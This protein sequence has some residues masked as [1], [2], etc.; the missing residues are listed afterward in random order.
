MR[1]P[2]LNTILACIPLLSSAAT[3]Q[4]WE[5]MEYGSLISSSVTLPWAANGEDLGGIVLKGVTVKLAP[6]A[7]ACFDTGELRWAGV[8]TN[9]REGLKLMGT[10][11]DGTHRPPERSRP[12]AIG[13]FLLGTSHGPGVA[14]NG[15]FRDLRSEPYVPVPKNQAH[16]QGLDRVGDAVVLHYTVGTTPVHELP[17]WVQSDTT[18]AFSRTVRVDAHRQPVSLLV[19]ELR[20][21]LRDHR[22]TVGLLPLADG[23]VQSFGRLTAAVDPLPIGARWEVLNGSRLILHLPPSTRP[24]TARLL[25]AP[26]A[27]TTAVEWIRRDEVGPRPA[28]LKTLSL[29]TASQ[30]TPG[31]RPKRWPQTVEVTAKL[32]TEDGAYA[33]DAVP[34][35]DENPWASWMRPGG[36]DFFPD[37]DRCAL[38]TW[39]G[40][41]WIGSGFRGPLGRVRW[42]RFAAGL[43][44]P[45]GLKIVR[46]QIHVLGRDQITRLLDIDGDGEADRYECF[47]NDVSIT[48]N[49]HEFSLDLHTDQ[50]GNFYFTKGGPLLGTDYWDPI[51]AHNGCV[52]KVSA[53]GKRLE[54]YATGLRAPNGSA[55]GQDGQVTC[56]D[57]EGIWTPVCR[58][59]WVKPGGFYGAM[60]L[61]HRE[62]RPWVSDPPLCWLPF[63]I[64]NSSGGQVWTD[65]RFGPLAHSL[66][67]LSYGKCRA[68]TV[69]R[70]TVG[71]VV[72][73][74]VVPLP[75][76][77][78]SS[79]MRAR[80]HPADGTL[81]VAGFKGWQTTAVR[82]G[83]LHRVRPTGRTFPRLSGVHA[84]PNH[85][86][87]EF[88]APLDRSSTLTADAFDVQ[89]WDY[90]WSDAY[91]S[92]LYSVAAP[93]KVT[94]KKGELRGDVLTIRSVVLAHDGR[95]VDLTLDGLKPAMQVMIR[96]S[97]RTS[98]GESIPL[99]YY[100]SIHR[101]K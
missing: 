5:A 67:H 4:R 11:Y 62:V 39:S 59:N 24:V 20:L 10:P 65:H 76:R 16:Y 82:D 91:G 27:P 56:S 72:Q 78:D 74:G 9:E 17:G 92:S 61:D 43:F 55:V 13:T 68:F 15:D 49:F 37:G 23:R 93:G 22:A 52:L 69:L 96:G 73:G 46:G 21:E 7:W 45:L 54:R 101:L 86:K 42:Q 3:P 84:S 14:L 80:I 33:V 25:V 32:G 63:A 34:L 99:E 30:G 89:E 36:F 50:A 75:W 51:G 8:W 79:A 38:C 88:N 57:N 28:D 66:I 87:L 97:L 71:G 12:A 100:G 90:R 35:P 95:S 40:D 70:E 31:E 29:A 1:S 48:P 47:N 44:Q 26:C 98:A 41:V 81:W 6:H 83:A 60:G 53:D 19:A 58:L 64:D 94:G 18:S 77:F 2:F 85:L